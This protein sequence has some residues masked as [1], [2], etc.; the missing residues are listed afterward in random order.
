MFII[1]KMKFSF[2]SVKKSFQ[3]FWGYL[4]T[5]PAHFKKVWSYVMILLLFCLCSGFTG[6]QLESF[7]LYKFSK[8]ESLFRQEGSLLSQ[9]WAKKI[10]L[11]W[12]YRSQPCFFCL[13]IE[14]WTWVK[15]FEQRWA[16]AKLD[17]TWLRHGS[18]L[19]HVN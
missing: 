11:Y 10:Y 2:A 16:G 1:E 15:R 9:A 6:C 17:I 14:T 4:K 12:N 7:L 13:S 19:T 5:F 8:F 3:Y 18:K